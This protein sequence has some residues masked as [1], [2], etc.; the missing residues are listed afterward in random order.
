MDPLTLRGGHQPQQSRALPR[1][2][3]NDIDGAPDL[4]PGLGE[5]L[6][7]FAGH[8]HGKLLVASIEDVGHLEQQVADFASREIGRPTEELGSVC[9]TIDAEVPGEEFVKYM[10]KAA[11]KVGANAVEAY[12]QW[13]S[14]AVGIAVRYSG[15]TPKALGRGD[16]GSVLP[17]TSESDRQTPAGSE[18]TQGR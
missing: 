10:Q 9:V 15:A 16:A 17:L 3:P 2:I 6:P 8:F 14:T 7:L 13:G 4:P 18:A 12:E 5:R 11:A 1:E